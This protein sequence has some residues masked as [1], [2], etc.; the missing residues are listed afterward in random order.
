MIGIISVILIVIFS[1][2]ITRIASIA[3]TH[4]GLS[5]E[6]SRFQARSAFTGVGFT[7]SESEKVVNHP[8]RR[9]I[10]QVLMILGNA[11]I[12]TGVASLIVGFSGLKGD[13]DTW[14]K[15]AMLIGGIIILWNLANSKWVDRQLSKIIDKGLK[16]YGKLQVSDYESLLHLS[17]E[18][19]ISEI[20]IEGDHWLTDKKL[21]NA[22]LR[23]EGMIVLGIT[24]KDG[25]FLGT[26]DGETKIRDGDSLTIYG[27]ADGLKKIEKRSKGASGNQEHKKLTSEQDEKVKEEKKEDPEKDKEK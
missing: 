12:A 15:I 20:P 26:P 5:R 4:T 19:R 14:I 7:T 27:R 9:R 24:R 2:I 21:S 18:Y 13:Q 25:T 17:G 6:S 8:V 11:G 1:I 10:L 3:L 22:K 23:D 16:K